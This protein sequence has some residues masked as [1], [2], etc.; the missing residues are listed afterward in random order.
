M[1]DLVERLRRLDKT[2][3]ATKMGREVNI[4]LEAADEIELQRAS[5][6]SLID[7]NFKVDKRAAELEGAL[8]ELRSAA[9]GQD[10]GWIIDI[11]VQ[12]LTPSEG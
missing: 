6:D 8:H 7:R 12:A 10:D 3:P 2:W 4:L 11:V 5:M 9:L 1:S